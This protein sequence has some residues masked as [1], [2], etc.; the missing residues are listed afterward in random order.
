[1]HGKPSF[2]YWLQYLLVR[3]LAF[4]ATIVPVEVSHEIACRFGDLSYLVLRKRRKIV[5]ANI[6]AA[7]GN[8]FC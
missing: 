7:L 2:N 3:F 5:L 8:S 4:L 6:A 1:M